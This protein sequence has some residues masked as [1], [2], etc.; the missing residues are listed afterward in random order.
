MSLTARPVVNI[1]CLNARRVSF[2]PTH[3]KEKEV[4][5]RKQQHVMSFFYR[6]LS[7]F[8]LL[9]VLGAA[10]FGITNGIQA[11]HQAH[12]ETAAPSSSDVGNIIQ[13]VF[14]PDAP[15]AMRIA[16][17]ES[18]YNP[19][20]INS[21]AI[22]DSYAEGLFQILVPSTWNTTSQAGNSPFDARANAI[23]AH[24]I[25][26]RDGHSWREWACQP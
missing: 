11:I 6:N 22:G 17:C 23:A 19:N 14:G 12:A 15:T 5:L 1:T 10:F 13:D 7:K 2:R 21:I 16:W 18:S 8:V 9:V 25:F 3:S 26:I 24:E 20:A 4:R